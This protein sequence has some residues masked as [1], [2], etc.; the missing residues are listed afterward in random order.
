ML[1]NILNFVLEFIVIFFDLLKTKLFIAFQLFVDFQNAFDFFLFCIDNILEN[2]QL[3]V[4]EVFKVVLT[5]LRCFAF[6]GKLRI[7]EAC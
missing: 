4:V 6:F 3:I 5:Q 1:H 7:I 2:S